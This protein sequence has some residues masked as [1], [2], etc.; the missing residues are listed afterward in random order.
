MNGGDQWFKQARLWD[1]TDIQDKQ[2]IVPDDDDDTAT[3]QKHVA[4]QRNVDPQ[5]SDRQLEDEMEIDDD[6]SSAGSPAEDHKGP[7]NDSSRGTASFVGLN[8]SSA[9]GMAVPQ[10]SQSILSSLV[11]ENIRKNLD[12]SVLE[13][14]STQGHGVDVVSGYILGFAILLGAELVNRESD[15]RQKATNFARRFRDGIAGQSTQPK[16]G[17][18]LYP[19]SQASL[20]DGVDGWGSTSTNTPKFSDP[21]EQTEGPP[22]PESRPTHALDPL[23]L[24]EIPEVQEYLTESLEFQWLLKR[25]KRSTSLTQTGGEFLSAQ[26]AIVK[27]LEDNPGCLWLTLDW[28]P[29][30]LLSGQYRNG[31]LSNMIVYSGSEST[32]YATTA[33]EYTGRV[34]PQFSKGTLKCF[35]KALS[36][37]NHAAAITFQ[38]LGLD[39]RIHDQNTTVRLST[40]PSEGPESWTAL[41]EV[42]LLA[43]SNV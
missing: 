32:C 34:W 10:P 21:S 14:I 37:S 39:V 15:I 11:A 26:T 35:E 38:G 5:P 6:K 40:N 30:T 31:S 7:A 41:V 19:G 33:L 20:K 22:V 17:L 4:N 25:I 43:I 1:W 23:T 24:N 12:E 42:S 8:P 16:G 27:A 28:N 9:K 2:D 3:A 36:N 29:F 18:K 13:S